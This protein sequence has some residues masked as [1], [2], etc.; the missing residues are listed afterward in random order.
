MT[1]ARIGSLFLMLSLAIVQPAVSQNQVQTRP[2]VG[3]RDLLDVLRH[4]ASLAVVPPPNA[5]NSSAPS[6]LLLGLA[7]PKVYQFASADYPGAG[8]SIAY[9][10]SGGMVVGAYS[11]SGGE[12]A[13]TLKNGNYA[14]FIPPGS[15]L[16]AATGINSN[17]EIVGG[18]SDVAGV[19][20]GFADIGGTF[21]SFDYPGASGTIA[22]EVNDSGVIVGEY[23]DSSN[24]S[25]GFVD[26]GGSF[27]PIDFP[28]TTSGSV[29]T[30]IN[31]AG[32]IVGSWSSSTAPVTGNGFLLSNSIYTT[33]N[34]PTATV[35]AAFGIND[36]GDISGYFQDA[37][38][39]Y[40]GFILAN[41]GQWSQVDV[42]GATGTQLAQIKNNNNI[43]GDYFDSM[44]ETHGLTG[45]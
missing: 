33:L 34:F 9:D 14:N 35:T 43:T 32:D 5:G 7:K 10:K 38:M 19:V 39:A 30:G 3:L 16:S 28:G 31:S 23:L 13:F 17:G 15:T 27:T 4:K 40:H 41:N 25:H 11:F 12:L 1:I 45:H 42:P 36:N 37:A 20:H 8:T 2:A 6:A 44:M 29:V 24:N 21:T 18:Y 26:I 22:F